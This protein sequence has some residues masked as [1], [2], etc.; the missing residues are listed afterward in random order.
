MK[1]MR[2]KSVVNEKEELIIVSKHISRIMKVEK[3]PWGDNTAN[4]E[5]YE[6]HYEVISDGTLCELDDQQLQAYLDNMKF[7]EFIN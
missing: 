7:V 4:G 3:M 5:V 6:Y 1:A 2:F